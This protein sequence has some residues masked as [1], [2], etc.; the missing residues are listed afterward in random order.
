MSA[1][2][3]RFGLNT[4]GGSVDGSFL[5][6]GMKFTGAD[7][8]LLD[9]ILAAYEGNDYTFRPEYDPDPPASPTL[10]DGGDGSLEAGTTYYYRVGFVDTD[11]METV[12]SDEVSIK[13][14]DPVATPPAP[15]L[16]TTSDASTLVGGLYYY[17]LTSLRD[18]EESI[19]GPVATAT[20]VAGAFAVEIAGP[21]MT[22]SDPTFIPP[23]S[24]RVWRMGPKEPGYTQIGVVNP[25]DVL[26]D[27][28]SVPADPC[29]CDPA[30]SPPLVA[31]GST[32]Y[33]VD[34]EINSADLWR[35]SDEHFVSW[36][37]YR[38]QNSGNY[39]NLSLVYEVTER[40]AGALLASYTDVGAALVEGVPKNRDQRLRLK[41]FVIDHG[42]DL[43]DNPQDYPDFYPF[44]IDN[45]TPN[46]YLNIDGVWAQVGGGGGGV[47]AV[48]TAPNGT[49]W[50]QT[51]GNNGE[52]VMTETDLPGP[53]TPPQNFQI[54]P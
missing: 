1:Q 17:A 15:S 34:V 50:I 42:A 44:V 53:P 31:V 7:R 27:D 35:L 25:G 16:V 6:D 43:P 10:S 47:P 14:P 20:L 4:F 51:V 32:A 8:L 33:S 36:R 38:T 28:G 41:P 45:G 30:S 48:Q 54:Q 37:L 18:T 11:G 52:I 49:R 40:I 2:T 46:L 39:S 29:A 3:P 12:A 24:F 13:T 21:L 26:L 9:R 22:S 5:D 23:D 19:L